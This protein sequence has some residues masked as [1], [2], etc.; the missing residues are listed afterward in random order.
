MQVA[1][2]GEEE[3][4]ARAKGLVPFV[5]KLPEVDY[6]KNG[7]DLRPI[8][9]LRDVY[10]TDQAHQ[11]TW[12]YFKLSVQHRYALFGSDANWIRRSLASYERKDD[13]KAA[14][15]QFRQRPA[16]LLPPV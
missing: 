11:D 5:K 1:L 7:K 6:N 16:V 2:F 8:D 3:T 12:R 9:P 4:A 13:S 10:N 15:T 14:I